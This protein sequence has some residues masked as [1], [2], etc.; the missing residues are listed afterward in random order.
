MNNFSL[1]FSFIYAYEQKKVA[2]TGFCKAQR[3]KPR[4]GARFSKPRA[5]HGL[6]EASTCSAWRRQRME[7]KRMEVKTPVLTHERE[8]QPRMGA[9]FSKPRA[10]HGLTEASTCSAWRRQRMEAKRMEVK[11]PVLTDEREEYAEASVRSYRTDLV[12]F[13]FAHKIN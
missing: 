10:L 8:E 13:G 3:T 5:L 9:R 7:A 6:T 11:T 12:C 1:Q 2:Y 4:M